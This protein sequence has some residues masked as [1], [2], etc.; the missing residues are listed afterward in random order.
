[1]ASTVHTPVHTSPQPLPSSARP[2]L[3]S[4]AHLFPTG[5]WT[6]SNFHVGREANDVCPSLPAQHL[7][8]GPQACLDRDLIVRELNSLGNE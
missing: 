5:A 1:M 7:V 2:L 4:Q 3:F 8:S 6:L